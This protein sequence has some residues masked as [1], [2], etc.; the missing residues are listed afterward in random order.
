MARDRIGIMGGTFDP[1][2][3]AH[4]Q[5]AKCA[6]EQ[7]HLESVIFLPAGD[8]PHKTDHR[9]TPAYRR[10]EMLRLALRDYP[11]FQISEYEVDKN[12]L[13]YTSETLEYFTQMYPDIDFYFIVGADSLFSMDE[14]HNPDICLSYAT[15]LAGNRLN[16]DESEIDRQIQ[17]LEEKYGGNI[18][19]ISMPCLDISSTR[20]RDMLDRGEDVSSYLPPAVNTY[21]KS[22]RLYYTEPSENLTMEVK[23]RLP[24]GRFLHTLGVEECARPMARRYGVD[25]E[26]AR[27]AALLHDVAKPLTLPE[28]IRVIEDGGETVSDEEKESEG[29]L[30]AKAGAVIARTDFGITDTEILDAIRY[31]TTGRP[32][33]TELEKIIFIA[34]FIEPGRNKAPNLD[35]IRKEANI[36]LNRTV[37]M[38]ARDTLVYLRE[39]GVHIDQRT[40][41]TY[42]FYHRITNI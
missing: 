5:L 19:K 3:L 39:K 22:N 6:C 34:D 38:I 40:V 29:V 8:P 33:M 12:G 37:C 17:H 20:I 32:A 10:V 26:K 27:T 13:S 21:I 30:H 25:E 35:K 11:Q 23:K 28:M 36:D 24:A 14:W 18:E 31:H 1:V 9:I 4:L 42:E 2:H 7:F 16:R 15:F 41:E